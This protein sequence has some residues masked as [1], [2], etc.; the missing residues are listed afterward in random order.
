MS[1][2]T[3]LHA[4]RYWCVLVGLLLC[5]AVVAAGEFTG[6]ATRVFDGDSFIARLADGTSIEV[7][8]G[9]IDAPEKNQPYADT[10]RAALRC[11]ILERQIRIVVLDTDQYDRKV[12]R[13]YRIADG[14]D[15]NA[16]LVSRGHA[17]VY[18]RHV[19]DKSLYERER[20][21]RDR[22]LGLWAL[23]EAERA[24]PWR[25]RRAHPPQSRESGAHQKVDKPVASMSL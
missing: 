15:I 18:R 19:K 22:R 7:R 5:Q 10:A 16:E 24:P 8:L 4:K 13:V 3:T 9:E 11:M 23:P 17:W 12:A 1:A 21:A 25:W 20:A 14:F 2:R 6:T